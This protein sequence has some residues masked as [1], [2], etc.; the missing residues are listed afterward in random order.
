MSEKNRTQQ[1]NFPLLFAHPKGRLTILLRMTEGVVE[2]KV[3]I[4]FSR[5]KN[6]RVYNSSGLRPKQHTPVWKKGK[7][8][9]QYIR[10]ATPRSLSR[11]HLGR[12]ETLVA[13]LPRG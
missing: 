6:H 12:T 5:K 10:V 13:G 7:K 1:A 2:Q 8:I 9:L 4:I 11:F 3:R